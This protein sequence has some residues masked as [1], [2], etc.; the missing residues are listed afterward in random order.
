MLRRATDVVR[1]MLSRDPDA[2]VAASR[3]QVR[4]RVCVWGGGRQITG[5]A[6]RPRSPS[7]P[8][9]L[10]S[11]VSARGQRRARVHTR[12]GARRG[13]GPAVPRPTGGRRGRNP[14]LLCSASLRPQL[15]C[16]LEPI[17]KLAGDKQFVYH[18]VNRLKVPG[19]LG[20]RRRDHK[21]A[22]LPAG[23]FSVQVSGSRVSILTPPPPVGRP[24]GLF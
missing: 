8:A 24:A 9:P 5:C 7:S 3:L 15:M 23:G 13:F 14:P 1:G 19:H 4:P 22:K 21:L 2:Q 20:R 12:M 10:S 18:L 11:H 6:R 17:E 16:Q